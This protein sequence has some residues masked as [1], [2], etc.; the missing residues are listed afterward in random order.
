MKNNF[1]KQKYGFTKRCFRFKVQKA[2]KL[3]ISSIFV[4]VKF[5]VGLV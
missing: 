1:R 4:R 3:A 5:E 2:C